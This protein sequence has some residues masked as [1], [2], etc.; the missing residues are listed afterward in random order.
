M[1]GLKR[2]NDPLRSA[3]QLEPG[4]RADVIDGGRDWNQ[5]RT[6]LERR[7]KDQL[8]NTLPVGDAPPVW[9]LMNYN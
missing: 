5:A 2:R 9:S 8:A 6:D 3:E 7:I 1:C 4:H